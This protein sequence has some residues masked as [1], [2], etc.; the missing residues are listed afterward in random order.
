MSS[1]N[2]VQVFVRIKQTDKFA[3]DVIHI[4]PD[5]KTLTINSNEEAKKGYINNQIFDWSFRY[6][7]FVM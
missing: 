1:K 2:H 7:L 5:K 3:N 6:D 4:L